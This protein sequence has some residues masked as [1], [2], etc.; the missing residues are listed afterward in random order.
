[1]HRR[2]T[3]KLVGGIGGA[4]LVGSGLVSA[5]RTWAR[6]ETRRWFTHGELLNELDRIERNA[7]GSV[8]LEQIGESL[9]GRELVVAK[10]GSGETDVFITTEQ[11]G[12]E[13]TG[14]NAMLKELQHLSR[15]GS[16]YAT[17]VREE[18]TVHVL[19]MHNPDGGMRNQRENADGVDPNRQHHYE[20][21]STDNPS[22][23]TQ[24]MID[25]V[26][27]LDPLWV[28][29]LHT[30]GGPYYGDGD[31]PGDNYTSS[32]FWPINENADPDAVALSRRLNVA[33]WDEVEGFANR[34]LSVYPGGT[35]GNIARNAY[36][37]RGYGSVLNEMTGQIPDK[38]ERM[39]GQMIRQCRK[40]N[41]VIL[42]ETA[43]GTVFDR[44]PGR[45]DEIPDRP[46]WN[47]GGEWPWENKPE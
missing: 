28:A 38:G 19:P 2:D 46:G 8:E 42:L 45:T 35:G 32:N 31:N 44:D 30:Q 5:E 39:E 21:G 7:T 22:P 9:E 37:I 34:Q 20:P 10:V 26:T 41:R 27:E 43:N 3:L 29:D 14:T 17:T 24:A 16:D 12:D 23:E 11:H 25:Y 1:M 6:E 36:G 40:E 18:L 13:P 33:M 4:S 47:E 15:S